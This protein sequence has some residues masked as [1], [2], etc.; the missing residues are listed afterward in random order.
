[1]RKYEL[2]V[3]RFEQEDVIAT[4]NYTDLPTTPDIEFDFDNV[5]PN[6]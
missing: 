1:M 5:P 3:V 2:E 4:S 6:G